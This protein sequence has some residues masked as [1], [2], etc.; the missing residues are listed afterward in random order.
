MRNLTIIQPNRLVFGNDSRM[1]LPEFLKSSRLNKVDIITADVLMPEL[2]SLLGLLERSG[3]TLTVQDPIND[4]PT[5]SKFESVMKKVRQSKPDVVIGI[6][7]GSVLDVA[8]VASA[9]VHNNQDLQDA[10]GIGKLS[11]RRTFLICLPTT[12]GTGSEVSPNALFLDETDKLKKA[13]ISPDLVPDAAYVDPMLTLNL[14][15]LVTAATAMDALTHCI[16]AYANR[17]AHP[18]I[19]LYAL[20]GIRLIGANI[21]RAYDN[22][23][24]LEARTQLSLASMYGGLCLGPVNTGAVHALSY[25][26]GSEF[27]IAHGISNALLLPHVMAFNIQGAPDRYAQ[28]AFALGVKPLG[29][30]VESAR[31]GAIAVKDLLK[32]CGLPQTLTDLG[33]AKMDIQAIAKSAMTVTRLLNNNVRE[34]RFEDAIKIYE[35]AL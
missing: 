31:A 5:V 8:K 4:E 28:I 6:G 16:E 23:N 20:E 3:M 19:D 24:D 29:S 18:M 26:L 7:G 12:S 15:A 25:P 27:H 17:F 10:F 30:K 32:G 34:V 22:G 13:V 2:E 21:K 14:P 9:M 11:K 35:G 1:E 33:I